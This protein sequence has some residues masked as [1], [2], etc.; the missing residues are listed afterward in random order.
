MHH[1]LTK[2]ID[3][4]GR[5]LRFSLGLILL[6]LSYF[7]SSWILL[8]AAIFTFLEAVMSWCVLYQL[9]GKNSCPTSKGKK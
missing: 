7:F 2:N 6:C 8:A 9:M 3:T 1:F 4:K 5:I